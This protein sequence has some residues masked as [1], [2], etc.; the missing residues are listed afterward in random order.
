MMTEHANGS[1]RADGEQAI[2]IHKPSRVRPKRSRGMNG[3]TC[4][5]LGRSRHRNCRKSR[6]THFSIAREDQPKSGR[7]PL[8]LNESE[9][10][11]RRTFTSSQIVSSAIVDGNRL[12]SFIICISQ[13]RRHHKSNTKSAEEEREELNL[14]LIDFVADSAAHHRSC[15]SRDHDRP[16]DVIYH[17]WK[18]LSGR[19]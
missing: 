17:D 11:R 13:T 12:E 1:V 8:P 7:R 10:R 15:A 3:S 4:S 19:I 16:A 2:S 18:L 6:M 9:P 14:V 5:P